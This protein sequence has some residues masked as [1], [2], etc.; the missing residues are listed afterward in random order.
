MAKYSVNGVIHLNSPIGVID[1]GVGGL[2]VA[3]EIIRQLPNEK[4][5]YLGDNARCPYGPRPME[6]VRSFTWEMTKYLVENKKIKMLVIAC[7]TATAAVYEEIKNKLPIPVIGVIHPGARAAIKTTQTGHIGII[8]TIGTIQSGAYREALHLIDSQITITDHACPAFVPLV[9]SGNIDSA[10]TY[11][12]VK[13]T[14]A[15]IMNDRRMD[16]LI[17]GCTHYPILRKVIQHTVG[18]RIQLIDSAEETAQEVSTLL[19][20][21]ELIQK[22]IETPHHEFYTTGSERMMERIVS[23]WIGIGSTVK[24]MELSV[25]FSRQS[26][27]NG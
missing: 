7:N 2:T 8:G 5:V 24:A 11:K 23:D 16:T 17:L 26:K 21:K 4:I 20:Y 18:D 19:Y 1:S 12:V 6:Q 10:E 3:K 13:E 27:A 25:F 22:E 14:L 9:E 15:P